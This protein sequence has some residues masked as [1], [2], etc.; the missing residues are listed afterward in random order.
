ARVVVLSTHGGRPVV[1]VAAAAGLERL[2]DLAALSLML[3]L[4]AP[5]VARVPGLTSAALLIVAFVAIALTIVVA[6]TRFRNSASAKVES[7][8]QR[9]PVAL[10]QAVVERWKDLTRGL[11]V[12]LQPRIGIPA[13]G[14]SIVVWVLTVVLQWLV[15]RAFQPAAAASDA[16]FM[17]AAVSLAIAL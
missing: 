6:L 4:V 15:L 3:A 17:V 16:A 5:V 8:T 1:E 11:A 2:L 13:A 7:V 9:L 10:R 14:G 12:L